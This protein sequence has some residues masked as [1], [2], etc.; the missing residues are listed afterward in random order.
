MLLRAQ[1][2][3]FTSGAQV[4]ALTQIRQCRRQEVRRCSVGLKQ[5]VSHRRWVQIAEIARHTTIIEVFQ[6][7]KN[8]WIIGDDSTVSGS[9]SV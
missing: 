9:Q 4:S 5:L 6:L 8:L 1:L 7:G 2:S 3:L